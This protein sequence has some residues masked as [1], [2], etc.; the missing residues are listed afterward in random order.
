LDVRL[1]APSVV[2]IVSGLVNLSGAMSVTCRLLSGAGDASLGRYLVRLHCEGTAC[3]IDSPGHI[4]LRDASELVNAWVA[5]HGTAVHLRNLEPIGESGYYTSKDLADYEGLERVRIYREG[6]RSELCVP[7]FAERR[8]V[9]TVN[10]EAEEAYE[11]E[12]VAETVAEYAQLIGIVLLES[13]RRIGVETVTEVEGLLDY[14]HRLEAELIELNEAIQA[15]VA[16]GASQ[17]NSYREKIDGLKKLVFMQRIGDVARF[18]PDVRV[19]D[20]IS[21]AMASVNWSTLKLPVPEQTLEGWTNDAAVVHTASIDEDAARALAFAVGQALHNVRKHGGSGDT[22]AGRRYP[23]MFRFGDIEVGGRRNLYVAV[24]STASPDKFDSLDPQRV[25]REPIEHLGR[26]SLGA[27]LAGE[28]LRRCGGS[29]YLRVTESDQ[30]DWIV[31]A[32]F[33]VPAAGH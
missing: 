20:A 23:A 7:I 3:A 28:G 22:L 26:V 8:L 25:F 4:D 18:G 12:A 21:A 31:D 15:E 13:R 1:I 16:L 17:R 33:S 27:F 6:I 30:H 10:L 5:T 19:G 14:R 32:E 24:S 11:F 29:A 2:K 9:G